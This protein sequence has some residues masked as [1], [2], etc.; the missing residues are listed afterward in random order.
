M[1]SVFAEPPDPPSHGG[2]HRVRWTG[3]R[4]DSGTR[5]E[6][7]LLET[8]SAFEMSE[9]NRRGEGHPY[10]KRIRNSEHLIGQH[11]DEVA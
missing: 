3:E 4:I 10:Y 9:G 6:E 2:N 8:H 1:P 7:G 11:G 5:S